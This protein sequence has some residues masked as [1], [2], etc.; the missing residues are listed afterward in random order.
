MSSTKPT[1]S[2]MANC[3]SMMKRRILIGSLYGSNFAIRTAKTDNSRISFG[4]LLF[5]NK[6]FV[7]SRI[8]FFFIFGGQFEFEFYE[9]YPNNVNKYS[10]FTPAFTDNGSWGGINLSAGF[11]KSHYNKFFIALTRGPY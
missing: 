7:L 2:Y 11:Y 8:H 3:R 4:E 9:S 6:Q 1:D 5:Q 10:T